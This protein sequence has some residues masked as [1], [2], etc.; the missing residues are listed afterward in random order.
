VDHAAIGC[1]SLPGRCPFSLSFQDFRRDRF[2]GAVSRDEVEWTRFRERAVSS[3]KKNRQLAGNLIVGLSRLGEVGGVSGSGTLLTLEFTV[4]EGMG[5]GE[6]EFAKSDAIGPAGKVL[7]QY[8]F[9]GA[10]IEVLR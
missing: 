6:L 4:R 8:E 10:S 3:S 1:F 9:V 2:G 7:S 5:S